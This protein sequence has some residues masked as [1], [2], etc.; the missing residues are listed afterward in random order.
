MSQKIEN[1]RVLNLHTPDRRVLLLLLATSLAIGNQEV[2]GQEEE[3]KPGDYGRATE[4]T[5]LLSEPNGVELESVDKNQEFEVLDESDPEWTEVQLVYDETSGWL[6][7]GEIEKASDA[8]SCTRVYENGFASSTPISVE[9]VRSK[10]FFSLPKHVVTFDA[11]VKP[12]ESMTLFFNGKPLKK[13]E[14]YK[15]TD[16]S[17]LTIE[18][19]QK[20]ALIHSGRSPIWSDKSYWTATY[21]VTNSPTPEATSGR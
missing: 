2:L 21:K 18:L 4:K 7:S 5:T 17:P 12:K 3:C 20:W 16:A 13:G 15:I 14:D 1:K 8:T 19:S 10:E 11:K 6:I 9:A